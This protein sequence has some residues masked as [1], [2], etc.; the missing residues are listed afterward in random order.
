MHIAYPH[1]FQSITIGKTKLPNRLIM[2]SMHT[3]LEARFKNRHRLAAFYRERA[4]GGV[5]PVSY[6]RLTLPTILLV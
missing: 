2:G 1:L 3:G 5:G 4:R 6:T